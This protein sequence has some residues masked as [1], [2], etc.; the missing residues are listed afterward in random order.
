MLGPGWSRWSGGIGVTNGFVR[1]CR[2]AALTGSSQ[3]RIVLTWSTG[4]GEHWLWDPTLAQCGRNMFYSNLWGAIT[5][6]RM[7]IAGSTPKECS[8]AVI[9]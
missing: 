8:R 4:T 9:K 6:T 7:G 5:G 2:Q 1:N 3:L